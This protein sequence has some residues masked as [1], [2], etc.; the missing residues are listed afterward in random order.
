MAVVTPR[1]WKT[2]HRMP[3]SQREHWIGKCSKTDDFPP[4]F[5][6][7]LQ[8]RLDCDSTAVR[9]HDELRHDGAAALRPK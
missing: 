5:K 2:S 4:T 3:R 8:L 7:R 1:T 6:R 9:P